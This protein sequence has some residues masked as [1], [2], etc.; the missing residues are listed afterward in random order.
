MDVEWSE[1]RYEARE[2]KID[3]DDSPVREQ[4]DDDLDE[5]SSKHRSKD[6]KKSSRGDEKEHHRSKDRE[7]PKRTTDEAREVEKDRVAGR[8]RKKEDRDEREK[9]RGKDSKARDKDYDREKYREKERERDRD[10]KDRSKDKEKDREAEKESDRAREKEKGKEKSRDRDRERDKAKEREREKHRD[11]EKER[12][13]YRDNGDKDKGKDKIREKER[14]TDRD[15]KE[16]SRDRGSRKTHEDDYE[17]SNDDRADYDDKR[18][19]EVGKIAKASKLNEDEKDGESSAH[20]SSAELEERILKMKETRTKKQSETASE[21]SSWVNKS[22][23]LEKERVLQRS[24]MFEEQDNIAVEGSEDEDTA[25]DTVDNL[26]GVKVLHGIEKVVEGGTVVLTIKDQ[27][28]LADGDINEDVD[29]LENVELGEQK[30][31]DEAYKAAKKKTGIYDDNLA[32]NF[33]FNDDP[34]VEKKILAKYDDPASEEGITLDEK[35]RFSGEAEKKLEELRRRLTGVSTNTFE[36]LNSSGKVSSDYFTHEEMLQFKKPKKKKS[37]RKKDKLDVNALEAEA[38]S[39]GLGVGDLGSRK[40]AR[41][42]AIK[43]EQERLEAERR[44]NAYEAAYAKADE[45][46]K[47]LRLGQTN[48]MRTEEDET[49]V[50]ADDDEDLRK[51][52]ER[53]RRLAVKKQEQGIFGP[54]AIAKLATSNH[55]DETVDDQ[56]TGAGESRENKVVFTE[57]EEF[58]GRLQIDEEARKPESEDVFMHDDEDASANA[59]A[60]APDEGKTDEAGGWTE[61]KETNVDEQPDSEDKEEVVPD[62]TIHEVAVGKGLSGAL[63]L[64]K[65]RGTLKESI[66]WGGRNMDKKKSKLVGIVDDEGKEEQK[67]KEIRIE[68]TDEFG[69]ILTPKEAFRM[70]SHKFHGKGPGKMKQEKRM[71]QYQEELKMKQMKSS[72]T[73]SL[74]V[75]RMRETQARL[76]TPYLVLSGHVKPGQTSDPKSGF[77][78]VEKD[79]PGGLTPMLGDRKVEHFLGIKRK[80]EPSNSDTTKKPKT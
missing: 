10:K 41:R 33:R 54:Q 78:T 70:L 51:S 19:E 52:L 24:K 64:L 3:K 55:N 74:S 18:E 40:D 57:M 31:R 77:A 69:R 67:K 26:A 17:L 71:K 27:P 20:L 68:R 35:G 59:N 28:I 75:E 38:I 1:S 8:E 30:R 15:N 4:Y 48:T 11:R 80:A 14:D 66:E 12:E 29:M 32:L 44:K 7:H 58:V 25:Q 49:P 22:R 61:V 79:L 34:S 63:K 72:D 65:D 21:I 2:G 46:S 73:P 39:A 23:K 60:N 76:Q 62:E 42:Q 37:L 45:A 13:S 53:A 16:R 43:A 50:F 36:D 9:D 6:R 56:N 47:L 5:K